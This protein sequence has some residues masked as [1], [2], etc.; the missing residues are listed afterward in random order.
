MAS[1][2][3]FFSRCFRKAYYLIAVLF[4]LGCSNV[5]INQYAENTPVLQLETFFNGELTAHGIVK[6]R[7]GE[8]I[9][10]FNASITAHWDEA[11][12]GYLD[13]QFVFDD[14]EIQQRQ[15]TLVPNKKGGYNATANDT[16]GV[17]EA[18]TAG[19]ALF[20]NYVLSIPYKQGT[21]DVAVD[22]RMYLVNDRTLINES[23]LKKF[24]V[25]VGVVTL[26]ILKKQE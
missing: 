18:V 17:G 26:V 19:N 14:G 23:V 20:L 24:G 25:K 1:I 10:Y 15:W 8:V 3:L 6:N 16:V 11:G 7:S 12:V 9:R 2:Y 4:L 21:L 5:D 13:E 22:D